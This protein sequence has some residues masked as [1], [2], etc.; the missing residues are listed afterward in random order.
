[1]SINENIITLLDKLYA[2]IVLI[3]GLIGDGGIALAIAGYGDT[4]NT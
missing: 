4:F 3:V 2:F 1:M